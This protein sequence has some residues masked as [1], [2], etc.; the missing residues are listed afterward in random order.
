[1]NQDT[2][3]LSEIIANTPP[4]TTHPIEPITFSEAK[5]IPLYVS[6]EPEKPSRIGIWIH[7]FFSDRPLAKV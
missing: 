2:S 1:V 3:I 7:N 5:E 6:A 4:E